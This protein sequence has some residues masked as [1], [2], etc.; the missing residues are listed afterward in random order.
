VNVLGL[1]FKENCPDLRNSK[2]PDI[3]REL[4]SYGVK[5]HVHDPIAN[6]EEAD[7][8]YG[9]R[10]STWSNMPRADAVILAVSHDHYSSRPPLEIDEILNDGGV[11]VDVKSTYPA[12]AIRSRGFRFWRL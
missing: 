4:Q 1:T 9:L 11:F 12:T 10:L 8:E 2:V 5:V 6:P 3:I 7:R